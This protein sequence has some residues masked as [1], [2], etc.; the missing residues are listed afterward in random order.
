MKW[1]RRSKSGTTEPDIVELV[2]HGLARRRAGRQLDDAA[3]APGEDA[4][5]GDEQRAEARAL[6]YDFA[7]THF[8]SQVDVI[9]RDAVIEHLANDARDRLGFTR[10][11]AIC[12]VGSL[13]AIG[14]NG[15]GSTL[16]RRLGVD[17]ETLI[18]AL[19]PLV[20]ALRSGVGA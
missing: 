8:S 14:A 15:V 9:R 11:A 13:A 6:L 20:A 18:G 7:L 5:P 19:G 3:A 12:T 10:L 17:A 1:L 16:A 4:L 2:A